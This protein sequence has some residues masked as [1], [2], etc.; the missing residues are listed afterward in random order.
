MAT[1]T[2]R[3]EAVNREIIA[4]IEAGDASANEYNIDA[5]ADAVLGDYEDG[6]S[7]KVDETKF[8]NIVA[9]NEI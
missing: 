1:Y 8:W 6:F 3:N 5:I 2:N 7:V 9:E 4:A